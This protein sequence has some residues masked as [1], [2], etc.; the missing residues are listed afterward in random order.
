[1]TDHPDDPHLSHFLNLAIAKRP[2]YELFNIKT[3]PSCL[4]N[5]A[6]DPAHQKTFEALKSKL[7]QT[8]TSTSDPRILGTGEIFETYPRM[9]K[10]R[11]FP[12]DD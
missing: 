2:E 5:L 8:L 9:S 7:N 4:T 1:M 10:V 12:G 6:D 3:D 11:R